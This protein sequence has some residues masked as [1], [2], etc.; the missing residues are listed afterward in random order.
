MS[1][2]TGVGVKLKEFLIPQ[3]DGD[4]WPLFPQGRN[5]VSI[6]HE[7]GASKNRF[8]SSAEVHNSTQCKCDI[9]VD[10]D[11]ILTKILTFWT[12]CIILIFI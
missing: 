1:V 9:K 10:D 8:G 12:L 4:E 7:A 6:G 5:L 2:C 3:V 11:G